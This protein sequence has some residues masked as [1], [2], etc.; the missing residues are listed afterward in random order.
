MTAPGRAAW[1]DALRGFVMLWMAGFHAC[2]DLSMLGLVPPQDFFA[3]PFWVVQRSLIVSLFLGCAGASLVLAEARGRPARAFW[4]RWAAIAGCALLVSAASWLLFPQTYISFGVLHG[5]ALMLLLTRPLLA[6]AGAAAFAAAGTVALWLPAWLQHPFFDHRATHWVGFVTY[7]PSV[8]DFVPLFPWIGAM[9]WG[10]AAMRWIAERRPGWL[11][12]TRLP[13]LLRPLAAL[14]R[15]P[16][17]FY[18][19]H[20]PVLIGLMLAWRAL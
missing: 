9:W 16:L 5:I 1:L 8:E 19:L 10:V 6:R 4:R 20:Q 12:P 15:W 2:V 17:L 13:S 18:M 11:A 14:G 7:K 3:D